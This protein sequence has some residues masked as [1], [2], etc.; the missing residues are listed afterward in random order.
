MQAALNT[1]VED[2]LNNENVTENVFRRLSIPHLL[3]N[4]SQCGVNLLIIGKENSWIVNA[5]TSHKNHFVGTRQA[6]G[7]TSKAA[8]IVSW[9]QIETFVL[10]YAAPGATIKV[11]CLHPKDGQPILVSEFTKV[12]KTPYQPPGCS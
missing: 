9:T 6:I 11:V 5:R 8:S 10:R 1:I 2:V 4:L 7:L 12:K 3:G